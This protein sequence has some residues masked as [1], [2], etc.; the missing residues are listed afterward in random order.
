MAGARLRQLTLSKIVPYDFV[1]LTLV[2]E[3]LSH[4]QEQKPGAGP[5]F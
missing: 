1:E 2:R 4:Q 3:F 5:G